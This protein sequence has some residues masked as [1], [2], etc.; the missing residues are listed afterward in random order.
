MQKYIVSGLVWCDRY[1]GCRSSYLDCAEA[2]AISQIDFWQQS[3]SVLHPSVL[4]DSHT[5]MKCIDPHF[6]PADASNDWRC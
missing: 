6:E 1:E 4:T 3:L 2:Q 5:F